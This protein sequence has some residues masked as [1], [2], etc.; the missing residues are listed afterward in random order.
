MFLLELVAT[1]V[2]FL[3]SLLGDESVDEADALDARIPRHLEQRR[4]A[5]L[6]EDGGSCVPAW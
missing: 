2:A 6:G 4:G 5:G 1:V 3:L